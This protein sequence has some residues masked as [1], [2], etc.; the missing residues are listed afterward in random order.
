MVRHD[1]RQP[2]ILH[3]VKRMPRIG[4]AP[5]LTRRVAIRL[6]RCWIQFESPAAHEA[7]GWRT[8]I[9]AQERR[10]RRCMWRLERRP[11]RAQHSAT[12]R[13]KPH[14]RLIDA[15]LSVLVSEPR[16]HFERVPEDR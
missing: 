11:R 14:Q 12:S 2:A 1:R 8:N 15:L 3:L 4:Y 7:R 9:L 6:I 10:D 13:P 5:Q 16:E